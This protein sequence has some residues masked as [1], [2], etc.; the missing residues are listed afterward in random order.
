MNTEELLKKTEAGFQTLGLD[1]HYITS[2]LANLKEWLTKEEFSIYKPQILH[3]IAS[4]DWNYLMDCFFQVIPFGTG[5]RR[6]EVGIGPNR[7]NEWT[8]MASAQGH[9][10]YLI[11]QHG[12]E[13]KTRGIVFTYDVRVFYTNPHFDESIDNPV[14]GLDGLRLAKA[15]SSVYTANGIKVYMFDDVRTTPELSFTIRHLHAIAGDMFSASHNPP[16]H[17]GKKV[18]DEF[19]GQLIPPF[20]ENLVNEVTQNVSEIKTIPYDQAVAEGKVVYLGKDVDDA[21]IEA[22]C[23]VTLS[24][25]RDIKIV[26]TPMH[27]CGGSSVLPVLRKLGFDVHV[28][29]KTSNPSGKFE[30]ITFN[31]PNPEVE[32]SFETPLLFAKEIDAD[33]LLNSDPD[34]DRF[35]IM[36]KHHDEWVFVNGNEMSGILC[37]YVIQKRKNPHGVVIKTAV[38]TNL[39][40]NICDANGI[41][42]IGDLL[43]GYKYIGEEMNKLEKEGKIDDL[44][45]GCEES[46]G[47]IAG[48]YVR[49]KDACTSAIWFAELAAELKAE[50]KTVIDYLEDIYKKY[51]YF[52]NYLTEIRLLGAIGLEKIRKIQDTL[53]AESPKMIG[54]FEV[55]HMQDYLNNLPI[56]SETDRNSKDLMVFHMKPYR[57]V[58]TAKVTI[59]PSGTEPKIKMYFELSMNSKERPLDVVKQEIEEELLL[60][61]RAIMLHC[62]KILG[63]DFPERGFMLFWQLPLDIKME[64][65]AKEASIANLLNLPKDER[66]EKL[67]E[68]LGFLGSDPIDKIGKAFETKYDKPLLHYLELN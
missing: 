63:V 36:V 20:D 6:G 14:A 16:D 38:T 41:R 10:Q 49:D 59:R 47:Y 46:H 56:L 13:A 60:L 31:I 5:G 58:Q 25:A 61:E 62:Y 27:G 39:M 44:L 7:I 9:S 53:R 68:M 18:Y 34:A 30:N 2:A 33:I 19:G 45:M 64:Y 26:Y 42:L 40:K 43:V 54:E 17:N 48:N 1:Q 22:A 51:G 52:R 67:Y 35:G 50:G 4:S 65:F 11:K 23:A 57:N 32:Q 8:I 28:D 3:F 15:A 29:P 66:S 12:E 21:Y 24:D 37:E 55:D